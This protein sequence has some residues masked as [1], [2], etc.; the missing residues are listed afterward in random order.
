M[1]IEPDFSKI[2][3]EMAQMKQPENWESALENLK[4]YLDSDEDGMKILTC[5]LMCICDAYDNYQKSGI[6]NDIFID[7]MKFLEVI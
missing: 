7:T 4:K 2:E 1:L 6:S 3:N 5:Q